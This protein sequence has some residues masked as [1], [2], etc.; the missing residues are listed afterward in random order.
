MAD[1]KFPT[2]LIRW[3]GN[4]SKRYDHTKEEIFLSN[5]VSINKTAVIEPSLDQLSVRDNIEYEFVGNKREVQLWCGVVVSTDP[6][7]ECRAGLVSNEPEAMSKRAQCRCT[8]TKG[9]S[10]LNTT[11]S[12]KA[13]CHTAASSLF[14]NLSFT[15]GKWQK[16]H[17][18]SPLPGAGP[19]QKRGR[20]SFCLFSVNLH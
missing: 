1:E 11:D 3:E 2:V 17:S 8:T 7:A 15:K 4:N 18:S 9:A 5:M 20:W 16:R 10:R 6:D 19:K 13:E 12:D 14:E